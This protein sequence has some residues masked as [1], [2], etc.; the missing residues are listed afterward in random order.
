MVYNELNGIMSVGMGITIKY[1]EGKNK[2]VYKLF[3][4]V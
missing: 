4:V 1:S 3:F 2:P